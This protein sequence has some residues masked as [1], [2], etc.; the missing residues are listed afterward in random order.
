MYL[1]FSF[2]SST[3]GTILWFRI[4]RLFRW[5]RKDSFVELLGQQRNTFLIL[6]LSSMR[7]TFF[8][9]AELFRIIETIICFLFDRLFRLI[10]KDKLVELSVR[11]ICICYLLSFFYKQNFLEL[12]CSLYSADLFRFCNYSSS[13]KR[14][15]QLFDW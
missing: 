13:R 4:G 5:N 14:V 9:L 15:G 3:S 6:F 8:Q 2:L 11:Q 12:S 10:L 7:G 1:S